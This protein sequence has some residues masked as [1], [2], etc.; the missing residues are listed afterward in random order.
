MNDFSPSDFLRREVYPR[1]DAVA[2]GLLDN[3]SL[4]H[5]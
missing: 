5:I 4:I 1:L 3:L 2:E